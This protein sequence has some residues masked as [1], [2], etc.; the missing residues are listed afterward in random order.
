M[1]DVAPQLVATLSPGL[2]LGVDSSA[3]TAE[4]GHGAAAQ[5]VSCSAVEEDLPVI[6]I[7]VDLRVF[8]CASYCK[9]LQK[10]SVAR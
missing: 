4:H 8:L 1:N 7:R 3:H 6:R 2:G 9:M 5:T 10:H